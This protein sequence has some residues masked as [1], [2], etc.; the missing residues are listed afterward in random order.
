[1]ALEL[2]L[3]S[4]KHLTKEE[5]KQR[6]IDRI[7]KS[8]KA[9]G[10][11]TLN[12][13]TN[14]TIDQQIQVFDNTVDKVQQYYNEINVGLEVFKSNVVIKDK[15]LLI[16]EIESKNS[17]KI[18]NPLLKNKYLYLQYLSKIKSNNGKP[19]YYDMYEF[20]IK[21]GI[22]FKKYTSNLDTMITLRKLT[23]DVKD[24]T[25][26]FD[27]YLNNAIIFHTKVEKKHLVQYYCYYQMNKTNLPQEAYQSHYK[28]FRAL[29]RNRIERVTIDKTLANPYINL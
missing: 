9:N 7:N 20:F 4:L 11:F 15:K 1:M 24:I 14:L 8:L 21:Y 10:F 3:S 28:L 18:L 6:E 23:R 16:Y 2:D 25:N 29:F 12:E 5:I 19:Y 22:F 26:H 27:S 17:S 13:V